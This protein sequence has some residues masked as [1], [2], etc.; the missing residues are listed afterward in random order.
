MNQ[1]SPVWLFPT[2][3]IGR[4]VGILS[5]VGLTCKQVV[6]FLNSVLYSTSVQIYRPTTL[7]SNPPRSLFFVPSIL[8]CFDGGVNFSVQRK[9]CRRSLLPL[10]CL[11]IGEGQRACGGLRDL[12]HALFRLEAVAEY[13]S[14]SRSQPSP[15]AALAHPFS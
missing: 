8:R 5:P 15:H 2:P 6:R 14:L 7:L 3:K 9:P 4:K 11:H 12:D 13:C 1:N 10:Y